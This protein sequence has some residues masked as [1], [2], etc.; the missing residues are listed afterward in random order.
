MDGEPI[1]IKDCYVFICK[2]K[3]TIYILENC[4]KKLKPDTNKQP[5]NQDFYYL[6]FLGLLKFYRT[7]QSYLP[8]THTKI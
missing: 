2:M 1:E 5:I 7:F 4:D 6:L 8:H 3:V